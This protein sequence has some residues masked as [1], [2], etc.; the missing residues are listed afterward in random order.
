LKY[1]HEWLNKN[2][3]VPFKISEKVTYDKELIK[4][5]HRL[6]GLS[7]ISIEGNVHYIHEVEQC[8]FKI[9]IKGVMDLECA[10]TLVLVHHPFEINEELCFTFNK[11][12]ESDEIDFVKGNTIDLSPYIWEIIFANIPMRVVAENAEIKTSGDGWQVVSEEDYEEYK[13][14]LKKNI[15]PRLESLK[16]YFDK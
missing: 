11:E 1:T 7:E 14:N 4:S 16:K 12:N 8:L 3:S 15:D 9:C 10:R 2:A 6:L 5:T 13:A